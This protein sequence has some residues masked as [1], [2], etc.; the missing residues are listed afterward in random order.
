MAMRTAAMASPLV[1]AELVVAVMTVPAVKA[2]VASS[3]TA[4]EALHPVVAAATSPP[5]AVASP[6][7]LETS[8]L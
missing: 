1:V 8:T 7:L 2:V 4:E 5:R 6:K 3:V